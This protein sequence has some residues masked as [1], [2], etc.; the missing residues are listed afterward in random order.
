[1]EERRRFIKVKDSLESPQKEKDR[2]STTYD[3]EVGFS[4]LQA[5]SAH[6]PLI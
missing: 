1:M 4:L 2:Q 3:K 6:L 5:S